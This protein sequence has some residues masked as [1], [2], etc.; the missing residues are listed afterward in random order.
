MAADSSLPSP[1]SPQSSLMVETRS[2]GMGL[3]AFSCW[4]YTMVTLAML[5]Q[6][7]WILWAEYN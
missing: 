6:A 1:P 4:V 7:G 2:A 3:D 5:A